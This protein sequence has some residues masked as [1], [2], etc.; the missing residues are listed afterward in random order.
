MTKLLLLTVIVAVMFLLVNQIHAKEEL[1]LEKLVFK[2]EGAS[3]PYRLLTPSKIEEGKKYPLVIFLHGAGERGTDNEKQL[4]HGIPDFVKNRDKYPAFVIVPQ[5]PEN[6][7]WADVDWT[8]KTHT[9][10]KEPSAPAKLLLALLETFIKEKP[11]DTNRIYLTG[12]S[13][14]GYGTWDLIARKPDLFAAAAPVC[15]GGDEATAPKIKHIP[16]WVFHGD[17]DTVVL[18]ERSRNMV[19]AIKKAGGNPKY[20]EYKGVGHNSW[21]KAYSDPEFFAW[22]FAQKRQP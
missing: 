9:L 12:L 1:P 19:E 6:Q 18:P 8:A 14:G 2:Q 4:V 10:P 16:L 13:M 7:K 11:V 15:G 5:C 22:L 17:K 20:T 3:L 21:V